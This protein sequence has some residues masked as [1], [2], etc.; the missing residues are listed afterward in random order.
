LGLISLLWLLPWARWAPRGSGLGASHP[1][2]G[3]SVRQI[4]R[5]RSAWGT[6]AGLFCA[7]Y[8]WYFLLTW[9]PLYLVRERHFSMDR[10]ATFGALCYLMIAVTTVTAGWIS[11][12]WVTAG[13]SL[14]R[15]RKTMTAGGLFFSTVIL[16]VAAVDDLRVGMVLLVLACMSFG[17]F[18]SSHWAITQTLAG[19]LAAGKWT[20]IQNGVGNLAG[21]VAPWLTGFVVQRAGSFFWAFA[22][23]AAVALAGAA[24]FLFWIGPIRPVDWDARS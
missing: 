11:D 1:R 16:P 20:G 5:Q 10:M 13:G 17:V 23:A 24:V 21:V 22:A 4:L 8:F 9:L 18:T 15:V 3:A 12:R 14:T 19:P 6:F 2:D 7:N